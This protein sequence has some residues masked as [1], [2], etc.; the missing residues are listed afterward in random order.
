MNNNLSNEENEE[1]KEKAKNGI[2]YPYILSDEKEQRFIR[3]K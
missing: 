3:R 1:I 2:Y